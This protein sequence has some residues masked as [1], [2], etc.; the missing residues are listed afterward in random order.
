MEEST[1]KQTEMR[2]IITEIVE[3]LP[4]DKGTVL[5]PNLNDDI[6]SVDS[7]YLNRSQSK[8][9]TLQGIIL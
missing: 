7:K 1:D 4:L 6:L 8:H 9:S 3:N 2:K 5:F